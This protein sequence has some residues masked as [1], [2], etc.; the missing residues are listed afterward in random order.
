MKILMIDNYDSFTYNLVQYLGELGVETIVRRNDAID[1][2]GARALNPD[3]IVVSPGPCTPAEAGH[4]N[5]HSARDG[6]RKADARRLPGPSMHG[7]GLWR[8]GRPGAAA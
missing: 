8:Q 2:A 1:V 5:V 4:L 3:A 7:R 6:G